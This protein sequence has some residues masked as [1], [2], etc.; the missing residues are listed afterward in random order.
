MWEPDA[1]ADRTNS[2]RA[3]RGARSCVRRRGADGPSGM[4]LVY[5][6]RERRLDR[7]VA[8]KVLP[9]RARG[10]RRQPPE[11]LREARTVAALTTRTSSRSTPSTR[12]N[13]FVFFRDG[14]RVG[15][16]A[17]ASASRLAVPWMPYRAARPCAT[18]AKRL[19]TRM[20]AASSPRRQTRQHSARRAIRAGPA[21]RLRHRSYEPRPPRPHAWDAPRPRAGR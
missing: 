3:A 16:N 17:R 6:A 18:S 21:V 9:P 10:R 7:R 11:V 5:V 20:P 2:A 15:R 13:N 12:S 14:V 19:A 1:R 8:I 4:G